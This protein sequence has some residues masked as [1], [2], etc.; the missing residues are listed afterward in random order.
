M[1]GPG[2]GAESQRPFMPRIARCNFSLP[3]SLD[4]ADVA[5]VPIRFDI[6]S[7]GMPLLDELVQTDPV[8]QE[9]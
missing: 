8:I 1:D 4:A 5:H 3:S 2:A 9:P 6:S 7:A